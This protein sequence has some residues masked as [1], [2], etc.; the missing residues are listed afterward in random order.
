MIKNI[1]DTFS[2]LIDLNLQLLAKHE[3]NKLG[4]FLGF[5]YLHKSIKE[6]IK[7]DRQLIEARIRRY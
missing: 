7:S 3:K 2:S 6:V 5:F 4:I 1:K